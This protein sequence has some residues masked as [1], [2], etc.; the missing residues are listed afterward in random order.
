MITDRRKAVLHLAEI[1]HGDWSDIQSLIAPELLEKFRILGF[2]RHEGEKWQITSI[3]IKQSL[4]YREPTP[5]ECE[6]GRQMYKLN[7]H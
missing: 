2:I 3:G 1:Q 7:I 4:F 5:E 6:Q